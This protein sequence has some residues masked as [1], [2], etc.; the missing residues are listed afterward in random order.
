MK[1]LRFKTFSK[2]DETDRIK[3]MKDSDIL[4]EEYKK[5][6]GV[7]LKE[8]SRDLA[9]GAIIGGV[10]GKANQI[11]GGRLGSS[12]STDRRKSAR[13][14]VIIA[15]AY[16]VLKDIYR[17]HKHGDEVDFYNKRLRQ[18]K[19]NA[20]RREKSDWLNNTLNREGYTY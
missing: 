5:D 2:Y 13:N 12:I 19:K 7:S 20:R 10:L 16:D 8:V 4:D 3:R 18:A 11:S 9:T 14:G 6:P 15:G 17:K 1:I